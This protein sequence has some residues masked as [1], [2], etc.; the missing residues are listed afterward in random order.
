MTGWRPWLP[1]ECLTGG[2]SVSPLMEIVDAWLAHWFVDRPF[3]LAEKWTLAGPSTAGDSDWGAIPSPAGGLLMQERAGGADI[4]A[5]TLLPVGKR[6]K[7]AF[8]KEAELFDRLGRAILDDLS[9]RIAEFARGFAHGDRS[10]DKADI[11]Q[12]SLSDE[13]GRPILRFRADAAFLIFLVRRE[14][15]V[16][17]SPP[18]LAK[19]GAALEELEIE[20][21]A[22][23][24]RARI[25]YAELRHL[26]AGDVLLLDANQADPLDLIVDGR[27]AIP[28]HITV[29]P[30]PVH[31]PI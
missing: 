28:A 27:V 19:R 5:A 8:R 9:R 6:E 18:P 10:S 31:S 15:T 13:A 17:Q 30:K 11:H 12:I 25:S 3:S 21:A 4:I 29:F 24:G 1:A 22:L 7:P 23:A 2:R 16:K 20:V 14:I 26:A